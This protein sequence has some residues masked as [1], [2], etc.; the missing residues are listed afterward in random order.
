[1][2]YHAS[3]WEVEPE[4]GAEVQG[5][6][7]LHSQLPSLPRLGEKKYISGYE[8]LQEAQVTSVS[9]PAVIIA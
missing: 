5:H 9:C 2:P 7:Q 4:K 8:V 6:A 1:M 3:A